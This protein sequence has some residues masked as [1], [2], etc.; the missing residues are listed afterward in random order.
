ME[1]ISACAA[2]DETTWSGLKPADPA[3]HP[4]RRGAHGPG[5]DVQQAGDKAPGAGWI[6]FSHF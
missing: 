6:I 2:A 3:A 4:L 5:A 1:G